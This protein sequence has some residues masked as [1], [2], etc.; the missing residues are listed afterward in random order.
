[1]TSC[2]CSFLSIFFPQ[3]EPGAEGMQ[4]AE[5]FERGEAETF[6]QETERRLPPAAFE[7]APQLNGL[8]EKAWLAAQVLGKVAGAFLAARL[9]QAEQLGQ[10]TPRVDQVAG[11]NL[12]GEGL[13]CQ[14]SQRLG[15]RLGER[16]ERRTH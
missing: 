15:R 1:M 11:V 4:H 5:R 12:R 9:G 10:R 7:L 14:G 13:K 2:L 8:H 16:R 3:V 6:S